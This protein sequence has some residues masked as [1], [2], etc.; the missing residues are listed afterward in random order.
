MLMRQA[1]HIVMVV[2]VA[3]F[4]CGS[5]I[6]AAKGDGSA[7][8]VPSRYRVIRLAFD[9]AA[10]RDVAL[11]SYE[12]RD[13]GKDPILYRWDA[14]SSAWESLT[15]DEYALGS[16]SVTAPNEII[17]VGS[18]S[19]LPAVLIAGAAQAKKVSRIESLNV[20][21]MINALNKSMAFTPREWRILSER[22]GF[23][24][25]DK[26][27]ERRRWGRYGP[28]GEQ[29]AAKKAADARDNGSDMV[30]PVCGIGEEGKSSF[31]ILET[32]LDSMS[33]ADAAKGLN[34][35]PE[36]EPIPESGVS[37]VQKSANSDMPV[38]LLGSET[39]KGVAEA[40]AVE[41][42]ENLENPEDK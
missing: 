3:V 5:S 9:V 34:L 17:L 11:V 26:N 31:E 20:V 25:K 28:P 2:A 30:V 41:Q 35:E 19:D 37:V 42:K 24:Y 39:E 4:V 15:V 16:F 23:T 21:D 40:V 32:E 7:L 36:D 14:H 8:V 18:S 33:S 13:A 12:N 27:E 10:L 6:Y 29:K 1:K 38:M 22:H